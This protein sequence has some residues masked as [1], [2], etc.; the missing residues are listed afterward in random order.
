VGERAGGQSLSLSLADACNPP[1]ASAPDLGARQHEGRGFPLLPFLTPFRAPSRADPSGL[2]H[3][4]TIYSSVQGPPGVKTST[5]LLE[6][7]GGRLPEEEEGE[8]EEDGVGGTTGRRRPA[9]SGAAGQRRPA[10]G[11]AAGRRRRSAGRLRFWCLRFEECLPAR[12]RESPSVSHTSGQAATD[13][14][15][16]NFMFSMLVH[17]MYSKS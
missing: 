2:G 17:I 1:T 3:A 12:S 9:A 13:L 16:C 6:K 8:E 7:D 5:R 10:A 14:V 4:A 15:R 11:G